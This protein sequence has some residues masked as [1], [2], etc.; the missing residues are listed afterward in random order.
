M[1]TKFAQNVLRE[2]NKFRQNP[3]SIQ[4]QCDLVRKGFSR[5]RHGDPFLKE[6]EYFIQE[7]QTMNSLPVLELNDNLTEAAKKEL[8]NFIGNESYKKYRRSGDLDGIVPDLFMKSNPAM[9]ADDGADEPINVLTKVLLD[10]QDRFKEGRNILCDPK[11]TQVGIAHEVFEEENWV[12]CIFA[13]KEEEPEPEID[14]PEGDLTELKKAF[15]ILDAKGTGKLDMVEIKKTMDNMRFYQTD[16]DL[17]SILKDLSDNDKCSW[18]K[19][20][21]YANKKLTDRKTQEGLETIFSLLIDDPDKDTITFETFRKICN[22]LDS[23]LSEEQIRDMLK[24]STKNG[25]EI[26]FEEFEEYMKGLEK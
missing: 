2:L 10:K 7:I 11:F 15:D 8:P 21:S 14:L 16:P 25:K 24:A 5:I 12:I 1:S 19:F 18:P 23:G 26:T 20:A 4:R 6:I 13:G 9:V 17:Y 3:R 22:E